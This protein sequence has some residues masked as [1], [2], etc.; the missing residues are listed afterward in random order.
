MPITQSFHIAEPVPL[1]SSHE[2]D[3]ELFTFVERYATNLVR[4]DLLVFFGQNPLAY[5]GA[6]NIAQ[7]VGRAVRTVQKELD[8]LVYLGVLRA[9]CDNAMM[10]Y[11]LAQSLAT[12]R[13]VERLAR[14]FAPRS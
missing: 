11:G 5:D 4:W 6:P 2:I 3:V 8:D 12:R 7:R 10:R 14:D 1:S 9:D 13:A